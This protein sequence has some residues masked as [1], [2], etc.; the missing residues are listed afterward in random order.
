MPKLMPMMTTAAGTIR[1]A[2][3]V[4]QGAAVAGLQA[5]ATAK[6]WVQ[7]FMLLML[8]LQQR[9]IAR[10]LVVDLLMCRLG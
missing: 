3:F 6:G 7:W 9:Q 10:V 1:P 4:I 8:G 2:K 5:I